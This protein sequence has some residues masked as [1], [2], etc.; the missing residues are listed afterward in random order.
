MKKGS[1]S[2]SAEEIARQA[3][4]ARFGGEVQVKKTS[5]TRSPPKRPTSP[6]RRNRNKDKQTLSEDVIGVN[7]DTI[8]NVKESFEIIEQDFDDL[9]IRGVEELFNVD[10][11][12]RNSTHLMYKKYVEELINEI[13]EPLE[14]QLEGLK[15][16]EKGYEIKQKAEIAKEFNMM[17][18]KYKPLQLTQKYNEKKNKNIKFKDSY[19][20]TKKVTIL[21]DSFLDNDT[22]LLSKDMFKEIVSSGLFRQLADAQNAYP[23]LVIKGSNDAV[24][25][26]KIDN[27]KSSGTDSI[28]VSKLNY[29]FLSEIDIKVKGIAGE[30]DVK[31]PKTVK[32]YLYTQHEIGMIVLR[33]V[34]YCK[35]V[36]FDLKK[37]GTIIG[38]NYYTVYL[39]QNISYPGCETFVAK[40]LDKQGNEITFGRTSNRQGE[41]IVKL[42]L[43]IQEFDLISSENPFE[44]Y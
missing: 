25:A 3:R 30:I 13:K 10:F 19:L 44:K 43:D 34:T 40:L 33:N 15:K 8:E 9:V 35:D 38:E 11:D 2:S 20:T 37:L 42:D 16:K 36:K 26:L 21:V 28:K 17:Y 4:L 29:E 14:I 32:T 12:K 39:G 41:I 27:N 6:T 18:S 1:T 7:E 23:F 22:C 31:S 5:P 24:I